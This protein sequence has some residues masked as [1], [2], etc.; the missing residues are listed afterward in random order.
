VILEVALKNRVALQDTI[1]D[2]KELRHLQFDI[3]RWK[4]LKQIRDLL[5]PFKDFTKMVSREEPTIT[6][7]PRYY[8]NLESL[9]ELIVKKRGEYASYNT[10]M[11]IAAKARLEVFKEY[12]SYIKENDIY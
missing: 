7:I 4:R 9:L 3:T 11:I 10:S 12:Y 2:H 1:N 8:T 6:H 5:K